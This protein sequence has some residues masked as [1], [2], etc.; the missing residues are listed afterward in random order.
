MIRLVENRPEKIA[1]QETFAIHL[2]RAWRE[3]ENRVIG[4]R[5]ESRELDQGFSQMSKRAYL[6]C[7][8]TVW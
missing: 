8:S 6:D 3:Q 4:W 2:Q 5:P 1:A 7:K